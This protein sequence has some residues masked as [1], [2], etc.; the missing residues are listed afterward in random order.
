MNDGGKGM[1]TR[2]ALI[3]AAALALTVPGAALAHNADSGQGHRVVKHELRE[4]AKKRVRVAIDHRIDRLWRAHHNRKRHQTFELGEQELLLT[5]HGKLGSRTVEQPEGTSTTFRAWRG[6]VKV[7]ALSDDVVVECK[8]RGYKRTW[9]KKDGVAVTKCKGIG[10]ASVTGKNF[11][12]FFKARLG[13]AKF[14]AGSVGTI[15]TWGRWFAGPEMPDDPDDVVLDEKA[16]DVPESDTPSEKP[17]EDTP[18]AETDS[19]T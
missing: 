12:V 18:A 17:A 8:G 7:W 11:M 4:D 14:P 15:H 6:V 19:T 5:G 3:L 1:R 9:T 2:L 10:T 13:Q 16:S